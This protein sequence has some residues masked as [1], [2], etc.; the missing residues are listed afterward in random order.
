MSRYQ[1]PVPPK[2][3]DRLK[4]R[5]E[6]NALTSGSLN[7]S[8]VASVASA[9]VGRARD[10]SPPPAPPGLDTNLWI[11]IGPSA[12]ISGMAGSRPRISG[13]VRDLAVSADG[14]RAYAATANGGVWYTSDAG[15]TWS[16]LGNWIPTPTAPAID[17]PAQ[18]LACGCLLVTFGGAADAS[19]DDVYVGT[20]ELVPFADYAP[21]G[22]RLGGVGIL[23]LD[24]S[25]AAALADP[26]G[27]HW[28]REAKNL[29]GA[30][31][32]RLARDPGNPN[33]LV[34][35]T[36]IGLFTRSGAFVE[37]ADWTQVTVDPFNFD[38]ASG[39][40]I[41]DVAWVSTAPARLWVALSGGSAT[42]VY[43]STAG[44]AGPFAP[45]NLP[46]ALQNSRL[47]IAIAPSDMTV[48]YVLGAGPH[49]WR[50][51]GVTA[52]EVQNLPNSLFV[53]ASDQSDYDLAVAVHPDNPNIVAAGGA[54]VKAD[55]EYSASLFKFTIT[56]AGAGFSA[57]FL[58]ANQGNPAADATFIGNGVHADVHQIVFVK[59]GGVV[60][61][62]VGCDGG[63]FRSDNAAN[64][65]TFV[66]R[67]TGLAVLEAGYVA[68]HPVS[69]G[70]VIAGAQDNGALIRVGNTVWLHFVPGT[71]DFGD[72]GAVVIHPVKNRY[73]AAQY[74][75]TDWN[76][77]GTLS[78]PVLRSYT[79]SEKQENTKALFY[80]TADLRQV[81]ATN[82]VRLAM[83]TNRVWLADN[84][85]PEA[86]ATA[87]VTLPSNTD[88]RAVNPANDDQDTFNDKSGS[89]VAC[90]WVDDDRL[91]VLMRSNKK[92]GSDSAVR[93]FTRAANGT[94]SATEIS[95]HSNKCSDFGNTDISQ[96]TSDFLPPLGAWSDIAVHVAGPGQAVSCYVGCTGHLG[97]DRMDTLW[98][99][100]GAGKWYPTGLATP[101][102][103]PP[104]STVSKAPVY[105]VVV[106]PADTTTVYVGTA[107]GVFRGSLTFDAGTSPPTPIWHF[108]PF[109]NGLPEAAVQ[110][111][112]FFN[113]DGVR[114]LRA[115]IQSRGVWE[116]DLGTLAAPTRLT[117]LRVHPTDARR[118][119]TT[120]LS[121]PLLP[122]P[123]NWDWHASPDIRLR[124]APLEGA[125]AAPSAPPAAW[126]GSS[127]DTFQ[128]WVFQTALHKLD[129][130]VRPNG[131]WSRQ[132]E[133]I[134]RQRFGANQVTPAN[135]T[136]TVVAANVFADPW[137]GADPTEADLFE[138]VRERGQ[139]PN[140]TF[141]PPSISLLQARKSKVDVL[142]HHRDVRPVAGDQVKVTLLRRPLDPD[143]TTW[144][145][146]AIAADWKDK[147][148]QLIGGASP[149]FPDNWTVADAASPTRPAPGT[150]DA[151]LPR[152][153]TFDVDFAGA[154][155]PARFL[156]LAVVH[157]T[158]DPI[159]V[160]SLIGDTLQN[161]ILQSHQV[162]ARVVEI[163]A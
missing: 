26:F 49:L 82:Q 9:E 10:I 41:T 27:N 162:A 57:G 151:R 1:W 156:L 136:A 14:N 28:K 50:I 148:V 87:W 25:V 104:G 98:W 68:C 46:N 122:G 105:A 31:I 97:A 21:P 20:G 146:I 42:G 76:T 75:Y 59:V 133:A 45:V 78:P 77:N 32:F 96:T 91:L 117:F 34:A 100:N 23:H 155:A 84:W 92:D 35:A 141:G 115:A 55:N 94:W 159:S 140:P 138:L 114:L 60:H 11:P 102:H 111:L 3:K 54:T 17:R 64:Q 43:T 80:N 147:V 70:F 88:P 83:G 8:L 160:G 73:F 135:W 126:N 5:M 161:L 95:S 81:G 16:P 137:D 132:F 66:S 139:D 129:P 113:A 153:V 40:R 107:V 53:S 106:D 142:I 109:S 39:K 67:N 2:G 108:Q 62:W 127:P 51:S 79:D 101:P 52:T 61:A 48:V 110:D 47:G 152:G 124:P 149:A 93:L 56:A 65:Y 125:E 63:V 144:P 128:L 74:T 29:T 36:S 38:A 158:P 22:G 24:G 103:S 71:G 157:S 86:A 130:R 89:I 69:A 119:P 154:A 121:N 143:Q 18:V 12:V 90:R 15:R 7:A 58:A 112:A 13:R 116:V 120:S 99:Y 6:Y 19:G 163:R 150:L 33:T 123:P 118:A 30:G 72:G 131:L 85:D 37:D 134:L 4:L 145:G 44:L